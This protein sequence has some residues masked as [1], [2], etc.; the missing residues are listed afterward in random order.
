M[1]E[2]LQTINNSLINQNNHNQ[3]LQ[4]KHQIIKQIL[5]IPNCFLK[6]TI[7]QA[8]AILR[9]LQIPEPNLKNTYLNLINIDNNKNE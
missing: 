1:I 6:M 5:E 3:Q 8:Y 4:K 7:E 9:D 2:K